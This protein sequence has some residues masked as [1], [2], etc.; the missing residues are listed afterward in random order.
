MNK[1]KSFLKNPRNIAGLIIAV[2][3]LSA[4]RYL[5]IHF[6]SQKHIEGAQTETITP[7]T[8]PTK[9]E[10]KEGVAQPAADVQTNE[11]PKSTTRTNTN[12]ESTSQPEPQVKT[13]PQ[14]NKQAE[15]DKCR[16]DKE[17]ATTEINAHYLPM[18]EAAQY[19]ADNARANALEKY[20]DI[21]D[22]FERE[23]L[24]AQEVQMAYQALQVVRG[25]YNDAINKINSSCPY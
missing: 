12:T 2:L 18:I 13:P 20:K 6:Y 21:F 5:P 25:L 16:N 8:D 4:V 7:K 17:A 10:E 19:T 22:P 11:S 24:V 3:V 14:D 23:K 9:V 15:I 1:I